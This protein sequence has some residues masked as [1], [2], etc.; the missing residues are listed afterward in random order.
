MT[1]CRDVGTRNGESKVVGSDN[2]EVGLKYCVIVHNKTDQI[3]RSG[4]GK[5]AEADIMEVGIQYHS[6]Q[7]KLGKDQKS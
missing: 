7:I 4:T 5:I 3:T 1:R 2:M 6:T